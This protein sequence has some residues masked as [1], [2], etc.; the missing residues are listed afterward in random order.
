MATEKIKKLSLSE[1]LFF[2]TTLSALA[3]SQFPIMD[4][5]L[6]IAEHTNSATTEIIATE[7]N[8]RL[9]KG[10]SFKK[11]LYPFSES[12]GIIETNM[13][14]IGEA[15]GRLKCML[16]AIVQK[17][18]NQICYRNKIISGITY[19]AILTIIFIVLIPLLLIILLPYLTTAQTNST[20][21][22]QI[23][24]IPILAA[25]FTFFYFIILIIKKSQES[26]KVKIF[27]SKVLL[28]IPFLNKIYYYYILCDFLTTVES[29]F[30]AGMSM[31]E[32]LEFSQQIFP[33]HFESYKNVKKAIELATKG[34]TYTESFV[35]TGIIPKNHNLLTSIF[36]ATGDMNTSFSNIVYW[37][38]NEIDLK[39]KT[40]SKI[41]EPIL[42][43]FIALIILPLSVIL[44]N[45]IIN[46]SL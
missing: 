33:K 37:L 41:I 13:L 23:Q 45:I 6:H 25:I 30:N 8:I 11:A 19:P 46:F 2:F 43:I 10:F 21:N 20:S 3:N 7:I 9:T 34:C 38:E 44:N 27:F 26:K 32:S 14:I 16:E 17:I 22:I 12:L 24:L 28:K 39:I 18:K 42:L 31:T 15:T 29:C 40:L 5:F 36:I 1:R 35:E 4:V